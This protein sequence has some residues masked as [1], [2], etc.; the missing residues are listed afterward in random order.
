MILSVLVGSGTIDPAPRIRPS[1]FAG[2]RKVLNWVSPCSW[3]A[4]WNR[5]V[6]LQYKPAVP[7]ISA[8]VPDAVLDLSRLIIS[9][10]C[11]Q[12]LMGTGAGSKIN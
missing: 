6:P 9:F 5:N 4:S 10:L 12:Q 1:P 8:D 11:S 7:G 3:C 2:D